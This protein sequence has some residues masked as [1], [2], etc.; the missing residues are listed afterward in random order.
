[1]RVSLEQR[2][3]AISLQH[4]VVYRY[5]QRSMAERILQ[6]LPPDATA[7]QAADACRG[8]ARADLAAL[9]PKRALA[10]LDAA[11]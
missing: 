6:L 9:R 7:A 10:L 8:Q 4:A 3:T 2:H 1:M 11:G 5:S